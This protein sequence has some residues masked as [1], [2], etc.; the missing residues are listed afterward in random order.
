MSKDSKKGG[1]SRRKF[2]Q[3]VGSGI[4]GSYVLTPGIAKAAEALKKN[5][6]KLILSVPLTLKV[7]GKQAHLLVEPRTTLAEVLR[8]KLGLTGTKVACNNGECGGCTVLLDKKAVYSCHILALDA[9]GKEVTTIEGI[10]KGENLHPI[11]Q[12][13]IDHDGLQCG[14]CTPGQVMAAEALLLK[15]PKPTRQDVLEGMSGNVCRCAAYP[16]IIESVLAAAEKA[17]SETAELK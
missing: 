8:E 17:G 7:N 9:E 11:Q 13:F 15:N 2:L 12:A 1:I 5:S 14:F 4:I 6:E 3:G 10:M 16:N